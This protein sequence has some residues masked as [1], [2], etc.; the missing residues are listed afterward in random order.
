VC[1]CRT[2][3]FVVETSKPHLSKPIGQITTIWHD[4][5]ITSSLSTSDELENRLQFIFKRAADSLRNNIL[6]AEPAMQNMY[7]RRMVTRSL[8]PSNNSRALTKK[9]VPQI[10]SQFLHAA[11]VEEL[12][13]NL[14]KVGDSRTSRLVDS[15]M[16]ID[17]MYSDYCRSGDDEQ[18]IRRSVS[19]HLLATD[20]ASGGRFK[21]RSCLFVAAQYGTKREDLDEVRVT[22]VN[23][24][25]IAVDPSSKAATEG[26]KFA[27]TLNNINE[28]DNSKTAPIVLTVA[29]ERIAHRLECLAM[30][31]VWKT[32]FDH[33]EDKHSLELDVREALT[34]MNLPLTSQGATEALVKIGRWT[35]SANSD[36]DKS[37]ILFEPWSPDLLKVAQSLAQ[38]EDERRKLY[39]KICY[40]SNENMSNKSNL[41]G[42]TNLTQLPCVCIDAQRT[43]F[44]DDTIGIRLRSSTGRKV[45]KSAS[46][47]E[48]LVHIADVSDIYLDEDKDLSTVLLRQVAERRGQSR[49]DLP[50]GEYDVAYLPFL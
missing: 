29:D 46:K 25:W 50:L 8:P 9:Q 14:L 6:P 36:Q 33:D 18:V 43:S 22:L 20:S 15:A 24:G 47:W 48:V 45:N 39:A 16:A 41:E 38:Y 42:R 37:K 2:C 7:N 19:A 4:F 34:Q 49:Y 17:Y 26:R 10:S 27:L 31:D 32:K 30:G 28:S 44:R 5:D 11:H 13:R 35:K 1:L 21:R 40:S 3:I 12:L 23:G